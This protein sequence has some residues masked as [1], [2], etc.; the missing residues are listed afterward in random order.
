MVV[1]SKG[2]IPIIVVVGVV[3]L[4]G[5]LLANTAIH[6]TAGNSV[7]APVTPSVTVSV[8]DT[9]P[10]EIAPL[11]SMPTPGSTVTS[12]IDAPTGVDVPSDN[13]VLSSAA[14]AGANDVSGTHAG[15]SSVSDIVPV[16]DAIDVLLY[17]DP[18]IDFVTP[19]CEYQ[20]EF[21]RQMQLNMRPDDYILQSPYARHL[22]LWR[23][24]FLEQNRMDEDY[25]NE[26]FRIADVAFIPGAANRL[27]QQELRV[28][29][30]YSVGWA[31]W[32]GESRIPFEDRKKNAYSDARIMELIDV[33]DVRTNNRLLQHVVE[34][35][36]VVEKLKSI[37]PGVDNYSLEI[38]PWTKNQRTYV[39]VASRT[40]VYDELHNLNPLDQKCPRASVEIENARS[41]T[42]LPDYPCGQA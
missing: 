1:Q 42:H 38:D 29:Y 25:F 23:L 17:V 15:N 39:V 18:V 6:A 24:A 40:P 3:V 5:T 21:T 4:A 11:D 35:K 41:W 9:T 33:V 36:K 14:V 34:C 8:N 27:A 31:T 2:F 28:I 30:Y 32:Y 37:S 13:D 22:K 26:H 12:A 16:G 20:S 19:F 10:S 7:V